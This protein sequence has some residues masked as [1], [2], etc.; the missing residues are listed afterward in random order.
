[1]TVLSRGA[2]L[3][4][5]LLALAI[6][7]AAL[8]QAPS[9]AQGAPPPS[10]P[11]PGGPPPAP[12]ATPVT[13]NLQASAAQFAPWPS[14]GLTWHHGKGYIDPYGEAEYFCGQDFPEAAQHPLPAWGREFLKS[15]TGQDSIL[16][17]IYRVKDGDFYVYDS[18]VGA[19]ATGGRDGSRNQMIN[20]VVGGSGAYAG[21]SGVWLGLTEGRG[22]P[23]PV[24]NGRRLPEILIKS[25]TGFVN[26]PLA[27]TSAAGR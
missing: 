11:P 1:M 17:C 4:A 3:T 27:A 15:Y 23:I 9:P 24:P 22:K 21:Y 25:M 19:R 13:L 2:N 6:A 20:L 8:A 12:A 7:P 5:L 26:A 18:V 10:G 16:F 14:G